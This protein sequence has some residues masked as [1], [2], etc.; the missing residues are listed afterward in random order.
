MF[1]SVGGISGKH[2]FEKRKVGMGRD[3]ISETAKIRRYRIPFAT[4]ESLPFQG[5][6]AFQSS[7]TQS[8]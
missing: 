4:E 6:K 3:E 8:E 5:F 7:G 1:A 2:G